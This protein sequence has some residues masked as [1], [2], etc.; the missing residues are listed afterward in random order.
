MVKYNLSCG[1]WWAFISKCRPFRKW[2]IMD[3]SYT[4][5]N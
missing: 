2:S 4:H 1:F 3:F 5:W